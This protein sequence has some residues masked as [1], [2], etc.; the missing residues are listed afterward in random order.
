MRTLHRAKEEERLE[1]RRVL[2]TGMVTGFLV[3]NERVIGQ[4][5][6]G[7]SMRLFRT[8]SVICRQGDPSHH[9]FVIKSGEV[10]LMMQRQDAKGNLYAGD[11]LELE[12][13]LHTGACFGAALLDS[14]ALQKI[15]NGVADGTHSSNYRDSTPQ[16]HLHHTLSVVAVT[17][18][19][20]L[21]LQLSQVEQLAPRMYAQLMNDFNQKYRRYYVERSEGKALATRPSSGTTCGRSS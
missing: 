6:A 8:G 7:A 19:H 10:R 21:E 12:P 3:N 1:V 2:S 18:L 13:R 14:A 4:I 15:V 11:A 9:L 20:V 16:H 17:E 5:L